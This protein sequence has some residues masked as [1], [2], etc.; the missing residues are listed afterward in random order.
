MI[1]SGSQ[2][3]VT[4]RKVKTVYTTLEGLSPKCFALLGTLLYF[5]KIATVP[6]YIRTL[7]LAVDVPLGILKEPV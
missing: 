6:D 4:S 2:H 3:T 5:R 1:T 7:A